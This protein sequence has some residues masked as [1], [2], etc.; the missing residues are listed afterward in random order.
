VVSVSWQDAAAYCN[1]LSE[2]DGLPPA[3]RKDGDQFVA[4]TP[5]TRGYRLLT[6][7]EWEWVARYAGNGKFRRYPWGDVLPVAPASGNYADKTA[8]ILLQ[9]VVP[10]YEDGYIATAPVG[11]FPA[12]T[13]GLN[14]I[15]G[16]V[17]EWAHDYYTVSLESAQ[18]VDPTGPTQ[19]KQ[20]VIRGSSWKQASVTDLRLSARDFGDGSRNDVGLRIAR[21]V[22]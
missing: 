5:M 14:D 19:G 10:D 17:A 7:A 2:Q 1:W 18:T 8:N 15:G 16:N 11:K 21:Y 13:L 20:H 12:N 9:D 3:Y 6:D 22:E 4:V